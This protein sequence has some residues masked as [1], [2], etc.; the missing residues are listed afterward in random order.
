M[1]TSPLALTQVVAAGCAGFSLAGAR[2]D[3]AAV[4]TIRA[5]RDAGIRIFETA[6][7]YATVDDATHNERLV[8]RALAGDDDVV[9]MTK[10]GHFRRSELEW[11][12]DNSPERLR[13]DVDDSL[14]ALGVDRLGVYFLHRADGVTDIP[15]AFGALDDL[16][17][18]GKIE[19]IGISNATCAQIREAASVAPLAAVENR[20]AIGID[21]TET[22]RCAE[23]LGVAFFAYSP[24]GGP[25]A[26]ASVADVVPHLAALARERGV[27]VQRLALRAIL[28]SSSVASVVVGVGRPATA[29]DAALAPGEPWDEECADALSRDLSR[30]AGRDG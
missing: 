3:D 28:A 24:L 9:I 4:R 22:L 30:D 5:A 25:G 8:A 12:V 1:T 6:R 10:G 20:L 21:S 7:A 26:A 11:G 27:S 16:R 23:D 2:D 17:R 15:A 18:A 13:R 14:R 19:A 29:R